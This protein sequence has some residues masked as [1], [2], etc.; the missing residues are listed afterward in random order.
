MDEPPLPELHEATLD[1]SALQALAA[2]I[3][4][5]CRVHEVRVK[6]GAELRADGPTPGLAEAL[7]LLERG[8]AAAVQVRYTHQGRVW[9][10]T[11]TRVAAGVRL[12]RIALPDS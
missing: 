1:A 2:D 12:V 3:L 4:T 5:L 6:R 8:E 7:A 11:L 9:I 10:D